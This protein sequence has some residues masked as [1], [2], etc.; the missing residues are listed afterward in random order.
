[1]TS[2]EIAQLFPFIDLSTSVPLRRLLFASA[3]KTEQTLRTKLYHPGLD[4][5]CQLKQIL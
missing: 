3:T 5:N 1:M 4:R 2:L